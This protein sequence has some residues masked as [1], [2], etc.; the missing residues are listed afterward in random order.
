MQTNIGRVLEARGGE[1]LV[2]YNDPVASFQEFYELSIKNP[3]VSSM[4]S[5]F[6]SFFPIS[7]CERQEY[8]N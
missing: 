6:L 4:F 3:E 5:F 1:L 7:L 2:S 8:F